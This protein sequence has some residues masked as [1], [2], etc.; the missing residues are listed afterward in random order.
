MKTNSYFYSQFH[1]LYT[2]NNIYYC[3]NCNTPLNINDL[4]I[5]DLNKLKQPN[6]EQPKE[7]QPNPE[8]PKKIIRYTFT[9]EYIDRF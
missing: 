8:Q 4:N 1:C 9:K 5:N 7:E 2:Q 6:T 3:N